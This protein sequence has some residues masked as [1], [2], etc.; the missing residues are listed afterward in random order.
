MD[1]KKAREGKMSINDIGLL[2]P[3]ATEEQ[4]EELESILDAMGTEVIRTD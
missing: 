1:I 2:L 4:R 3:E